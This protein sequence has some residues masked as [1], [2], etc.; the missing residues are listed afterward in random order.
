MG[1]RAN[2]LGA[3]SATHAAQSSVVWLANTTIKFVHLSRLTIYI[4]I[5]FAFHQSNY[6][7]TNTVHRRLR[8]NLGD[9]NFAFLTTIGVKSIE[10]VDITFAVAAAIVCVQGLLDTAVAMTKEFDERSVGH[11]TASLVVNHIS[12]DEPVARYYCLV[13]REV[14]FLKNIIVAD[15]VS[16][17]RHCVPQASALA[18]LWRERE[19]I[20][21]SFGGERR[22][23]SHVRQ[24]AIR[25]HRLGRR[26][27][28]SRHGWLDDDNGGASRFAYLFLAYF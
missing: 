24:P 13:A 22:A 5:T 1:V 8:S 28:A 14:V 23:R 3:S 12:R 15:R 18:R 11:L 10:G 19:E 7:D 17:S 20:W 27:A 21:R 9:A 2:R 26:F 4:Y 16:R 25:N 6:D